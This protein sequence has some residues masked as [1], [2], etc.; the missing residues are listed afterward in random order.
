MRAHARENGLD[1]PRLADAERRAVVQ[2]LGGVL[3][4]A[5]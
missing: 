4:Q 5:I 3:M 1:F 2:Q